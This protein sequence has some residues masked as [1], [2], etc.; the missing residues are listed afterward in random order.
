MIPI[1]RI[2]CLLEGC[3]RGVQCGSH[4]IF[5]VEQ[6]SLL[7]NQLVHPLPL[8]FAA[9]G[10]LV[11]VVLWH[12]MRRKAPP[13]TQLVAGFLLLSL[14]QVALEPLRADKTVMASWPMITALL[15]ML[16]IGVVV[17]ILRVRLWSPPTSSPVA[18]RE[19]MGGLGVVSGSTLQF[20]VPRAERRLGS[21]EAHG[22]TDSR[23]S[24]AVG[25]KE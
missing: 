19:K 21:A 13:G 10:S 24:S 6:R 3:C 9:L 4:A 7:G 2:G 15:C 5:C 20:A 1:G 17:L 25:G 22:Q 12:L 14:G 11:L 8:Y 18:G 23:C 16:V